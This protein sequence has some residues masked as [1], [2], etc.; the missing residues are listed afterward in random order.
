MNMNYYELI[1]EKEKELNNKSTDANIVRIDIATLNQ[2]GDLYDFLVKNLDDLKKFRKNWDIVIDELVDEFKLNK[3]I[4]FIVHEANIPASA[5]LE[6]RL[7]DYFFSLFAALSYHYSTDKRTGCLRK[8][9]HFRVIFYY[10]DE[11][12]KKEKEL[13]LEKIKK[14]INWEYYA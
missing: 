12:D 13:A 3:K 11:Q 8:D 5:F 14:N 10:K 2:E 6:K 9:I 1:D 4:L 7:E